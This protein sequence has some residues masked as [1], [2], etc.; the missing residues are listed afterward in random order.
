MITVQHTITATKRNGCE[1]HWQKLMN[2]YLVN[3]RYS[4]HILQLFF[5]FFFWIQVLSLCVFIHGVLLSV[6]LT[7][8][9][10]AL[11]HSPDDTNL[12]MWYN[13]IYTKPCLQWLASFYCCCCRCYCVFLPKL[14]GIFIVVIIMCTERFHRFSTLS[15]SLSLALT[16]IF[17]SF[18]SQPRNISIIRF[19]IEFFVISVVFH[20]RQSFHIEFH[21]D[22]LIFLYSLS[23]FPC[24]RDCALT[25]IFFLFQS[26]FFFLFLII[27]TFEYVC[28]NIEMVEIFSYYYLRLIFI[29]HSFRVCSS[30]CYELLCSTMY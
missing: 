20:I 18:I 23:R 17:F 15:L 3:N 27:Q 14:N 19:D 4:V 22:A 1:S 13:N 30:Y 11:L 29:P 5:S 25:H 7:L 2:L 16:Y 6:S 12:S 24:I 28:E 9:N 21:F 10:S 8:K 26:L